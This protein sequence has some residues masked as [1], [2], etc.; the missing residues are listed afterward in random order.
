MSGHIG[1][2]LPGIA[3]RLVALAALLAAGT[4]VVHRLALTPVTRLT[5]AHRAGVQLDLFD[6][7]TAGC[8]AALLGC[9]VWCLLA[10]MAV[11]LD[12]LRARSGRQPVA[13]R[14]RCPRLVHAVVLAVLGLGY[15]ATPTFAETGGEVVGDHGPTSGVSGLPLP[16]R[17]LTSPSPTAAHTPATNSRTNSATNPPTPATDPGAGTPTTGGRPARIRVIAGDSLWSVTAGLLPS[18]AT[19]ADIDRAWRVLARANAR[20]VG[21]D[22]DLIFPGTL[23]RVPELDHPFGKEHP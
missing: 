1:P 19:A 2:P 23:L 12:A 5:A 9:W 11:A 7:V 8:G 18:S 10:A 3:V 13:G 6:V 20:V 21:A 14:I 17:P 22:P 15:G 4:L 16:D